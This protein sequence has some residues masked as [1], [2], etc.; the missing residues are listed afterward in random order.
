MIY[1]MVY[2]KIKVPNFEIMAEEILTLTQPQISQN[3]RFWDLPASAFYKSTPVFFNYL[4]THFY[5]LPI[6]FRFYNTPPY[7]MLGPHIDNL[8][9]APNKIGFNIP[10]SGTKN[11]LMNYYTTPQDNLDITHNG[12]FGAMP[13][14]IIKDKEKLVLVDSLEIDEPTLVRTD[15]IHEVTNPNLTYRLVLG[16][17][18][19]GNT[20]EDI[21]KFEL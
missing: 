13:A 7:G 21:Y 5:R 15:I 3:L 11:T 1:K 17:K 6:L 2:K 16:M 9:T 10:L 18:F 19:V 20:F 8:A 12:G 4:K 14:Q